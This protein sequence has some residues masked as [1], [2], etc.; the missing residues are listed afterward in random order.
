[1]AIE[2]PTAAP[3]EPVASWD[4]AISCLI[5]LSVQNGLDPAVAALRSDSVP[6]SDTL[7]ISRLIELADGF[8]LRAAHIRLDWD[9]LH[10]I[11]FANPI[12][13]ILKNTNTVVLTG[14][15][16][17]SAEEVAVWDP[18]HRDGGLLFVPR[19]EFER[20]WSGDALKVAP[21]PSSTGSSSSLDLPGFTSDQPAAEQSEPAVEPDMAGE[22]SPALANIAEEQ[23][24][25]GAPHSGRSP[26]PTSAP[27]AGAQQLSPITRLCIVSAVVMATL[28]LGV[29][30][31]MRPAA[32]KVAATGMPISEAHERPGAGT[33]STG[34]A[35]PEPLAARGVVSAAS[36][37]SAPTPDSASAVVTPALPTA[38]HEP[39]PNGASIPAAPPPEPTPA[40][41]TPTPE[42]PPA[43]PTPVA[44]ASPALMPEP[45]STAAPPAPAPPPAGARLSAAEIAALLARGD[46]AFSSGDVASARL[47]Y[48]RAADAGDAQAAV[49]LGETFD[50]AFLEHA[51]LRSARGDLAMALSWYRRAR[52]LG[53]AEAEVLLKSLEAK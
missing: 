53:A 7:S 10:A 43:G 20:A 37:S 8:G 23:P 2:A 12:L 5:R 36:A 45:A 16:R 35:A 40:V 47:Y 27:R 34:G 33:W 3:Q 39:V 30:L 1:M 15:G 18:L 31:F 14:G 50:P 29:F 11:G 42:R 13:V 49:R 24:S 41:V 46:N 6:E 9:E 22:T 26:S 51:R 44:A 48:G 19:Q 21:Q 25:P 52:D 32:E 17:D 38:L 28:G 4:T